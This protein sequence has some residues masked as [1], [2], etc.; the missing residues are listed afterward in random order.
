MAAVNF[1]IEFEQ[2]SSLFYTKGNTTSPQYMLD[3]ANAYTTAHH[4][5]AL[6]KQQHSGSFDPLAPILLFN[7]K[8]ELTSYQVTPLSDM[9]NGLHGFILSEVTDKSGVVNIKVC[10]RGVQ[11]SEPGSLDRAL[12]FSGPGIHSFIENAPKIFQQIEAVTKQYTSVSLEF[13]GHSLGGADATSCFHDFMYHYTADYPEYN[14]RNI[15]K[16]TLNTLNTP[17]NHVEL[18]N[19]LQH[20]LHDN[21]FC[22][23]PLDVAI[24]ITISDS[25]IISH[26][27]TNPF[28]G[29][30]TDLAKV[31]VC[32][33]DK[34]NVTP[35]ST[36]GEIFSA[37]PALIKEAI[38][39]A[40]TL[41]P[42][43]SPKIQPDSEDKTVPEQEFSPNFSYQYHHNSTAEGLE[44]ID[45]I[46]EYKW[47]LSTG[48]NF[49]AKTANIA[50]ELSNILI[51]TADNLFA[52]STDDSFLDLPARNPYSETY[53]YSNP[54]M[55]PVPLPVAEL[56]PSSGEL[57]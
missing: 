40:H 49:V 54:E 13:T 35:N 26:V 18:Q 7:P 11:L 45:T 47:Y 14:F 10:F 36:W 24:N 21:K 39:I 5:Y 38:Y 33:I 22:G 48:I 19:S 32:H 41:E 4:A 27:G 44:K 16:V 57:I 17:G 53:Y 12:E 50:I 8:G 51:H 52:D 34:I 42:I 37:L 31:Q 20:L 1:N 2:A 9:P 28:S 55:P 29:I 56:L 43:F 25:D 23:S 46:L 3:F 15:E 30:S 6:T